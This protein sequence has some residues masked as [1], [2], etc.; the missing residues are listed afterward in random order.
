[1]LVGLV[2]LARRLGAKKRGKSEM[3]KSAELCRRPEKVVQGEIHI[4]LFI[5]RRIQSKGNSLSAKRLTEE[6]ASSHDGRSFGS[7]PQGPQPQN[8]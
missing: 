3:E 4:G 1:M 8:L 5:K 2:A 7:N 6:C